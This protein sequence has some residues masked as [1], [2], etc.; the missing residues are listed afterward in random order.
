MPDMMRS[1]VTLC[2]FRIKN[3]VNFIPVQPNFDKA[4]I[5]HLTVYIWATH[6]FL[7]VPFTGTMV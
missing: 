7:P 2:L 3:I 6:I 1:M 5:S 4:R